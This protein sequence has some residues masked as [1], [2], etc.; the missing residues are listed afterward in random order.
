L[1]DYLVCE[2]CFNVLERI[3][4]FKKQCSKAHEYMKTLENANEHDLENEGL[5]HC[6]KP[7]DQFLVEEHGKILNFKYQARNN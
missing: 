7:K 6:S 1:E 3:E 4:S 5:E 2:N